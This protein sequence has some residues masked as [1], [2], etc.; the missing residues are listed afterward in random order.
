MKRL[1]KVTRNIIIVL[2]VLAL[3][4]YGLYK[5][6]VSQTG[7]LN[8]VII[9]IDARE[10]DEVS[11]SDSLMVAHVDE[12][13]KSVKL[14]SVPR[15]SYV[16]IPDVGRQ[17]KITHAYAYGGIEGTIETMEFL[18]ETDFEYYIE[19]DFGKMIELVD[20]IGGIELTPTA[21]FCEMNENDED[22]SYCFEEGVTVQMDGGMAL[23]YSRH[24]KSDSDLFRAARQQEVIKAMVSKV[25]DSGVMGM[26]SFY[27]D[28]ES[29]SDTNVDLWKIFGYSDMAFHDFE[30]TQEVAEGQDAYLYDDYYGQELYYFMMD[31]TWLNTAIQ[32]IQR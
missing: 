22:G 21:T 23:A 20:S 27:Q 9:G 7:N 5:F 11:R 14:I 1:F 13:H 8:V 4:G 12:A 26:Y 30:F 18:F 3:C 28:V 32:E 25:K 2:I 19:V 6:K 15:D 24:R 16:Y 29:I 17:D 10:G 31:E